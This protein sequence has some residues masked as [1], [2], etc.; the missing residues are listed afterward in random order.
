MV[1]LMLFAMRLPGLM[2]AL[3]LLIPRLTQKRGF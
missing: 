2:C 3:V 1:C